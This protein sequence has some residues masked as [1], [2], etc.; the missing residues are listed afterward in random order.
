MRQIRAKTWFQAKQTR[1]FISWERVPLMV[2]MPTW[3][4]FHILICWRLTWSGGGGRTRYGAKV[5]LYFHQPPANYLLDFLSAC[6]TQKPGLMQM[7][8]P[9]MT[10]IR[11]KNILSNEKTDPKQPVSLWRRISIKDCC[12]VYS[13]KRHL[14]VA[15]P[16]PPVLSL[17]WFPLYFKASKAHGR[18]KRAMKRER[19]LPLQTL[20]PAH[21]RPKDGN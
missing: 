8:C 2:L 1:L 21:V 6:A 9:R 11:H 15:T 5:H 7:P 12:K 3:G 10:P 20:H 16:R 4:K 13:F 14:L 17:L 18:Y 19:R